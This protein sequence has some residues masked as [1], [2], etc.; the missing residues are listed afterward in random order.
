MIITYPIDIPYTKGS[1]QR[2]MPDGMFNNSE[3][4]SGPYPMGKNRF[5]HGGVHIRVV[6]SCSSM[7]LNSARPPSARPS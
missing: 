1:Q 2:V 7:K 5:W 4:L 3:I 6:S